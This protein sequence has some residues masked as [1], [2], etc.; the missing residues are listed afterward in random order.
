M[1]TYVFSVIERATGNCKQVQ[2]KAYTPRTA[3]DKIAEWF[4]KNPGHAFAW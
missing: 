4:R 1:K 2:I 3:Q